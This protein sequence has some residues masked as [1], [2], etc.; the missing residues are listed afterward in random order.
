MFQFINI[1]EIFNLIFKNLNKKYKIT[2]IQ[3]DSYAIVYQ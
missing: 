3:H 2:N 1:S